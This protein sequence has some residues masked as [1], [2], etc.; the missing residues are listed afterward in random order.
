MNESDTSG[1]FLRDSLF[2]SAWKTGWYKSGQSYG[3]KGERC[4]MSNNSVMAI[5]GLMLCVGCRPESS[6]MVGGGAAGASNDLWVSAGSQW[7]VEGQPGVVFGMLKAP[8]TARRF[9]YFVVFKHDFPAS[10]CS[11]PSSVSG[12]GREFT[13]IQEIEVSG[14]KLQIVHKADFEPQETPDLKESF[15]VDGKPI[16]LSGGRVFLVDL[17]AE[18]PGIKQRDVD[19]PEELPD[20]TSSVKTVE[21]LAR[22]TL[23]AIREQDKDVDSFLAP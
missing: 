18:P 15:E 2:L 22:Q 17:T 13:S 20:P 14:K 6:S 7:I 12:G 4:Q 16:D 23:A 1:R 9:T 5:A 19:L 3:K 21:T 8:N 11:A 10:S